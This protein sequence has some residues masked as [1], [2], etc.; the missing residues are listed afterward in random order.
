MVRVSKRSFVIGG[1]LCLIVV[2]LTVGAIR[3]WKH[4]LG[5]QPNPTP[6]V[7]VVPVEQKDV[8]IYHEWIG[9]L[10]G[11]VNADV[12]AQVTGYLLKQSYQ[13]D[14]LVKRGQLLFQ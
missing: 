5:A 12:R 11:F 3:P 10:D 13:K 7:E 6:D 1:A 8:P 2:G 9:T 4:A 14:P